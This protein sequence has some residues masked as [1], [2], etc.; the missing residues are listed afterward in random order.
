MGFA[1]RNIIKQDS[2]VIS[3]AEEPPSPIRPKISGFGLYR[4]N[5]VAVD[6]SS[7]AD[8]LDRTC[9]VFVS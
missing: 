6:I 4:S 2:V 7:I 8:V 9:C 5:E 3:I 1:H